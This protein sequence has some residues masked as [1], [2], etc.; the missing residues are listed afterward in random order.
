[1]GMCISMR[2]ML[3]CLTNYRLQYLLHTN[4]E[5]KTSLGKHVSVNRD[6]TVYVWPLKH[7]KEGNERHNPMSSATFSQTDAYVSLLS[8]RCNTELLIGLV[9]H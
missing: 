1:M 5:K 7:P 9:V 3:C 6:D 2:T 8:I 4:P